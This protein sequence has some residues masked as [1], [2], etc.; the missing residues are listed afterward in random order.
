VWDNWLQRFGFSEGGDFAGLAAG[1]NDPAAG[2]ERLNGR[3]GRDGRDGRI[4][5]GAGGGDLLW[6]G[7]GNPVV[8]RC[9]TTD[10]KL[11]PLA[12]CEFGGVWFPVVS[13]VASLNHRLL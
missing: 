3:D 5:R 6:V 1:G 11:A 13:L 9:S 12:G 4:G 8:S 2:V 7:G 10:Y